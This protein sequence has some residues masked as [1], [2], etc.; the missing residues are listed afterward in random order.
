MEKKVQ[1]TEKRANL[2]AVYS[3]PACISLYFDLLLK[4]INKQNA[5]TH[6]IVSLLTRWPFRGKERSYDT[7]DPVMSMSVDVVSWELCVLR[8]CRTHL[9]RTTKRS[10]QECT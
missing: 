10:S 5:S 4:L 6:V 9:S 7:T 1:Y 8:M 3:I 2:R